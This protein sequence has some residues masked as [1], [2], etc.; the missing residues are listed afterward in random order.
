MTQSAQKVNKY[1]NEDVLST[2]EA[3]LKS[4]PSIELQRRGGRGTKLCHCRDVDGPR[5]CHTEL[6]IKRETQMY[7]NAYKLIKW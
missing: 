7:I 4:S 5:D 3:R 6:V 1:S 2:V